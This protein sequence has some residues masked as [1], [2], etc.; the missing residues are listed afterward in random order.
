MYAT[1]H[2]STRPG[3]DQICQRP[4]LHVPQQSPTKPSAFLAMSPSS[5]PRLHWWRSLWW[6]S[7]CWASLSWVAQPRCM[8]PKVVANVGGLTPLEVQ[9]VRLLGLALVPQVHGARNGLSHWSADRSP[10]SLEC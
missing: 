4:C 3:T 10:H 8:S 2:V 6:Q 5:R 1:M 9:A 7:L